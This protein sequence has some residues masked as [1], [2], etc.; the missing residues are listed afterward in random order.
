MGETALSRLG[1]LKG[2]RGVVIDTMVLIYLFEAHPAY[3]DLCESLVERMDQGFFSGVVTPITAAEILVK[4]LTQKRLSIADRYRMAIRSL[5]NVVLARIDEE[6]AF[7]A[8]ALRAKYRL[9]LPDM[10]QVAV[11]LSFPAR[12]LITNDR[13]LRKVKEVRVLLLDELSP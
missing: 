4:P 1:E 11:A 8:G 7:M 10:L 13:A 12:T 3:A 2:K 5:P 6:I 9:P